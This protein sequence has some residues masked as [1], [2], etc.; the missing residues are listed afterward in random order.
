MMLSL[1][2]WHVVKVQIFCYQLWHFFTIFIRLLNIL[3]AFLYF[4]MP[5]LEVISI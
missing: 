5:F 2:H 4:D 3:T 1:S